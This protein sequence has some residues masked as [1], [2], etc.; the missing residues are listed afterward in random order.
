MVD[1]ALHLVDHVFLRFGLTQWPLYSDKPRLNIDA[2]QHL[3]GL[4][5]ITTQEA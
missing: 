5:L 1:I 2:S 4:A 3:I